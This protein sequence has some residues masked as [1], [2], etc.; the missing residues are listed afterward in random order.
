MQT[1]RFAQSRLARMR[2]ILSGYIERKE[3]PGLVALISHGDEVHIEAIPKSFS[4]GI[5]AGV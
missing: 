2:Q 1:A 5:P 3:L 4:V